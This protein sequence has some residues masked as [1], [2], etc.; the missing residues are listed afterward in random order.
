MK[1]FSITMLLCVTML[2]GCDVGDDGAI[3]GQ[4]GQILLA[5]EAEIKKA[6]DFLLTANYPED[7]PET[8][9]GGVVFDGAVI[10]VRQIPETGLYM[11]EFEI[12]KILFGELNNEEQITIHSPAVEKGGIEFK[13]GAMYRV[14]TVF[15]DGFY[16]T[17]S[18][19]G[20]TLIP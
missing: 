17:W 15:I 12:R 11:T 8:A 14:F 7:M 20:T 4:K 6:Q 10:S 16:R 9:E 1:K 19:T 5:T 3:R 18:S 2:L 13:I